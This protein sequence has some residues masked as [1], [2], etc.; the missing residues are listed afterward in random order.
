MGRFLQERVKWLTGNLE[1][2]FVYLAPMIDAPIPLH[3]KLDF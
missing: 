3:R 2:L 1:T